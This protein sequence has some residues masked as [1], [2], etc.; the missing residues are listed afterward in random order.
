MNKLTQF[1]IPTNSG[2]EQVVVPSGIPKQLS[3]GLD[4]SGKAFIQTGYQ[5]LFLAALVLAVI[6]IIFSG[7]QFITSGGDSEKLAEARKRLIYSIIGLVIVLLA[8]V[9]VSAVVRSVGGNPQLFF[10]LR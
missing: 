9:I 7:I 1:K 3:G 5:Y 4:S 8:F 10:K 2:Q 6:F